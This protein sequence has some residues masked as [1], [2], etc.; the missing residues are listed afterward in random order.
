MVFLALLLFIGGF[1]AWRAKSKLGFPMSER[2]GII[3]LL[4]WGAGVIVLIAS[5][6]KVVDPASQT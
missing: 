6:A 3:H 1:V 2:L 4:A 5:M